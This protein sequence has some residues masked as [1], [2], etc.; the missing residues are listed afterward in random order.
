MDKD[1][2]GFLLLFKLAIGLA[3]ADMLFLPHLSTN[4]VTT[5]LNNNALESLDS[6]THL[7]MELLL[8]RMEMEGE[9]LAEAD[10]EAKR[11]RDSLRCSNVRLCDRERDD[12][13]G[14]GFTGD[15]R[16]GCNELRGWLLVVV[17]SRDGASDVAD[18]FFELEE[19]DP[20]HGNVCRVH[21]IEGHVEGS[22]ASSRRS[23]PVLLVFSVLDLALGD[24]SASL[25]S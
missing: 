9:V 8:H 19:H 22:L 6:L 12:S 24:S 14:V 21:E 1:F 25:A 10:Q 3:H 23:D 2:L 20:S 13:V 16:I 11:L 7:L 4:R 18:G 17:A 15:A 5:R